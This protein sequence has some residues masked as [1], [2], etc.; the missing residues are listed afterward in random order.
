M[1]TIK[2]ITKYLTKKFPPKKSEPWDRIGLIYGNLQQNVKNILV[3][4]D[5][6]TEVFEF[7]VKNKCELIIIHHPFFFEKTQTEDYEHAPYK[8]KIHKRLINSDIGVFVLHTN[9]DADKEGTTTQLMKTLE[10]KNWQFLSNSNYGSIVETNLHFE[11]IVNLIRGKL[12]ISNFHTNFDYTNKIAFNRIAFLPGA[13]S[14]KDIINAHQNGASLIFTS[15]IKWSTW[16]TAQEH[17]IKL[18]S[19]SHSVEN[20]FVK[21]LLQVLTKKYKKIQVFTYKVLINNYLIGF[22]KG[23]HYD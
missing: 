6:T 16:L 12:Q 17:K 22:K 1:T 4:L 11:E 9:Y 14:A 18:V 10:F 19:Y 23:S 7:A 13:G 21:H 15:D 5:L 3:A 20:V 8:K 2:N